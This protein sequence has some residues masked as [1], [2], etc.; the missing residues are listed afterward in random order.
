[1]LQKRQAIVSL[2]RIVPVLI[3]AMMG[4]AGTCGSGAAA[5]LSVSTLIPAAGVVGP[6]C[7]PKGQYPTMWV[8]HNSI[9]AIGWGSCSRRKAPGITVTVTI[10]RFSDKNSGT[11][12][13]TAGPPVIRS[14][15]KVRVT[16]KVSAVAKCK[17][18]YYE[19]WVDITVSDR[20]RA[21]P[22][23][24]FKSQR[25]YLL[26]PSKAKEAATQH[27]RLVH[28]SLNRRPGGVIP[29]SSTKL[30]FMILQIRGY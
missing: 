5:P 6:G 11:S 29:G 24:H 16:Q 27:D 1:M 30:D 2:R 13:V 4:L 21:I 23:D 14:F 20:P 10:V 22:P 17:T 28:P 18:G 7:V 26:C 19:T 9:N 8:P 12:G 3:V 25:K 15:T